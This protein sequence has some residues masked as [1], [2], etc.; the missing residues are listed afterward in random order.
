MLGEGPAD[1]VLA[2]GRILRT[3][4][5][6][7]GRH[8]IM[9]HVETPVRM[10]DVVNILMSPHSALFY[11]LWRR[12]YMQ[13]R[14]DT[15]YF[16]DDMMW[17]SDAAICFGPL[18]ERRFAYDRHAW[19]AQMADPGKHHFMAE[20]GDEKR[21]AVEAAIHRHYA[22]DI[23]RSAFDADA[24]ARLMRMVPLIAKVHAKQVKR[25]RIKELAALE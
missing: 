21:C 2:S 23:V 3:A 14:F 1:N 16:D 22:E 6:R 8:R 11:Q 25:R 5:E 18:V 13:P 17:V 7:R 20:A 19:F 12:D 10:T 4:P 24:R 9:P 15:L